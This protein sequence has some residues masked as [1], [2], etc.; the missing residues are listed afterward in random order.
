MGDDGFSWKDPRFTCADVLTGSRLLLLPFL[1][2][3][4]VAAL[5]GLATATL[6]AMIATDLVDGRI[7]RRSGQVRPFGAMLDSTVDFIVIYSLFTAFFAIGILVWWRWLVIATMGAVIAATQILSIR[8]GQAL[9][10]EPVR[11]GKLVGQ[12]QF[13]YLPLLLVRTFWVRAA[14]IVTAEAAVFGALAVA[15][16]AS[17]V[18]HAGI[19][20]RLLS[21]GQPRTER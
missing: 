15:I 8:R 7:A 11:F 19:L 16:A 21:T 1:L 10:F 14:W 9:A 20:H 2:Y 17:L 4:L 12:V 18:D 13:V 5:P 6:A 3:A